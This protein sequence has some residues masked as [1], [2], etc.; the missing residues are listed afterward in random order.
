MNYSNYVDDLF[1]SNTYANSM[2]PVYGLIIIMCSPRKLLLW[3]LAMFLFTCLLFT[4]IFAKFPHLYPAEHA[5]T[6]NI[7][8]LENVDSE[9]I[10]FN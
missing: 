7:L 2:L 6:T 5:K 1:V 9:Y 3:F 4:V 10:L 8:L